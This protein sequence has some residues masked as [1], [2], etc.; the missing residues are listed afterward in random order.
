MAIAV[1]QSISFFLFIHTFPRE[2]IILKTKYL[3]SIILLGL[4]TIII[5]FTPFLFSDVVIE[6][7]QRSPIVAPGM[8]LFLITAVGSLL[9]GF[10]FLIIRYR[11]ETGVIKIQFKYILLGTS[12]MFIFILIFNF[13]LV[14]FFKISD[15]VNYGPFFVLPFIFV[16]T[17]AIIRYR[18]MDI[19]IVL[20]KGVVLLA[21][22]ITIVGIGGLI[23]FVII[24]L[25]IIRPLWAGILMMTIGLIFFDLIKNKYLE[26]ANRYFFT[27]LFSYEKSIKEVTTELTTIIDIN[28]I[29]QSISEAITQ[30]MSLEKV[31][32]VIIKEK[33]YLISKTVGYNRHD[34][35][36]ILGDRLLIRY[37][38][39]Y[40][41]PL[42]VDELEREMEINRKNIQISRLEKLDSKLRDF[43]VSVCLPLI[44]KGKMHGIII[45]GNKISKDA[46]TVEDLDL[47]ETMAAQ[48][49]VAM[50]NARLYEE[51]QD[52][53]KNLEKKIQ[54]ATKEIQ[55]KNVHLKELLEMKSEFLTVASHQLR[56]PTSVVRGMLSMLDEEGDS[57][58]KKERENFIAQA[59]MA[60][61]NLEHIVHDLLSA[62]E[63]E[64]GKI[65]FNIEPFDALPVVEDVIKERQWMADEKKL[66]LK[67][68]K[69][70]KKLP[71]VMAD[72]LKFHELVGN[73]VDNGIHYT[74][75]GTVTVGFDA[76]PGKMTVWVKDTGIGLDQEEQK[77][78][79]KRFVRGK[80]A[81]HINPNGT[82]LGLYIVKKVAE[83]M[84]SSV[85]AE[86]AGKGKGST[87]YLTLPALLE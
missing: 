23:S 79:F 72:K 27:S 41:R 38:E 1:V 74:P 15:F 68:E 54:D 18:F 25:D 20:R 66:K 39:K 17:Y 22:L 60:S 50:E 9:L 61:N 53:N 32:V 62:T 85:R 83:S 30:T 40:R 7:G 86:S 59:Y 34:I 63:L 6:D 84:S 10:I 37:L 45:L 12:L 13:F 73:M 28:K 31:A 29:I 67:L 51:V 19:R 33:D 65:K 49:A 78:V 81:L 5:S 36:K 70:K 71:Q 55:Q 42:V 75:K 26:W 82:G 44:T 35:D 77:E 48:A 69:P 8:I 16:T 4:A 64:G 76:K 57:M 3:V 14:V 52:L 21:V 58:D 56:T 11:K 80:D 47:L 2:K 87:F 43:D 24:Q 46:F